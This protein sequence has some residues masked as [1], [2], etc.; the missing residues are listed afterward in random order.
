MWLLLSV[1]G[2]GVLGCVIILVTWTAVAP[3]EET[4][5][6]DS[7]LSL[8]ER[9]LFCDSDEY[10][11]FYITLVV[12]M[13]V[14]ML[15]AAVFAWLTREIPQMFNESS[16]IAIAVYN[17]IVLMIITQPLINTFDDN[18][19]EEKTL[20]QAIT[21]LYLGFSTLTL[22]VLPKLFIA[23]FQPEK[24]MF[25]QQVSSANLS[26]SISLSSTSQ[27]ST[28]ATDTISA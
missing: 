8:D 1:T 13:A 3:L 20:L 12:Y 2:V 27:L 21:P 22:I 7:E 14:W 25:K 16:F 23:M 18:Q 17:S 26:E 4:R 15:I 6:Q 9:Y 24:N 10:I 11:P 19:Y 28:R 5:S